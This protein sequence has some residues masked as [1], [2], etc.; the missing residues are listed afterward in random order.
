MAHELAVEA[1]LAERPAATIVQVESFERFSPADDSPEA[2]TQAEFWNA[3]RFA[4]LDLTLGRTPTSPMLTLLSEAGMT[5]T[6]FAFLREPRACGQRWL[7]V[8]Y[9]I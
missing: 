6:D 2:I 4:A 1:I 7:G 5:T 3:A 8:D 9:Y